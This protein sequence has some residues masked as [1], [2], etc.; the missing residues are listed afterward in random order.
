MY[1]GYMEVTMSGI[2]LEKSFVTLKKCYIGKVMGVHT[3]DKSLVGELS[4][5]FAM[6]RVN[7]AIQNKEITLKEFYKRI[8]K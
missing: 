1:N 4:F 8:R 5:S 7:L 2:N 6:F 3:I